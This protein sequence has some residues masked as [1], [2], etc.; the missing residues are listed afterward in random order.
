M[1]EEI[2]SDNENRSSKRQRVKESELMEGNKAE[3]AHD[4][5]GTEDNPNSGGEDIWESWKTLLQTIKEST[6]LPALR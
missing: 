4:H 2:V 3:G 1:A 5:G 6:V